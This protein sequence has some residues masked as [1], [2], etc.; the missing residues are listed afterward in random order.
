MA[1][2]A[3]CEILTHWHMHANDA[4][5]VYNGTTHVTRKV[6]SEQPQSR[7]QHTDRGG[8]YKKTDD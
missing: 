3:A 8:K 2:V 1:I 5:Q 4:A 7:L 6:T